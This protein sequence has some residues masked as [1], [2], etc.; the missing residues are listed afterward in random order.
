M[1]LLEERPEAAEMRAA[2]AES[3]LNS[4][5]HN[6]PLRSAKLRLPVAIRR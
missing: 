5:R 6:K 2:K 4:C 3:Q 1:A